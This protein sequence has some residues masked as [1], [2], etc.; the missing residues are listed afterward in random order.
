MAKKTN[1]SNRSINLLKNDNTARY[2]WYVLWE[3]ESNFET[4][5]ALWATFA[6][7]MENRG[8][9]GDYN[10]EANSQRM[11][12]EFINAEKLD[13]YDKYLLQLHDLIDNAK[14]AI[15]ERPVEAER[16]IIIDINDDYALKAKVD[17]DYGTY[18][19]DH[20]T[21]SSFTKEEEKAEK[22]GQQ[23]KLYQY[24]LWKATGEKQSIVFCEILKRK[25][26]LPT[27]KD[28]L[29]AML[30]SEQKDKAIEEKHTVDTIKN[31]LYLYT[32][33]DQ[34]S[35]RLTFDR[36]DSLIEYVEK[37]LKKAV[38]KAD[39]LKTLEVDEVL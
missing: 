13:E 9:T 24:A 3:W 21:V 12:M 30:P 8:K 17:A 7:C 38:K 16:E 32:T 20:K 36:D 31:T 28:D 10:L 26:I 6:S 37:L 18:L 22:Y 35:Q 34:V 25:A 14:I 11:K 2:K 19:L 33:A 27:K 5:F 23:A 29:I 4:Y 15:T 39:W 1:L